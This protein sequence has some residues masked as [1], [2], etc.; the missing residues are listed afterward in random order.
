MSSSM[1]SADVSASTRLSTESLDALIVG[2]GPGG[3]Y[4]VHR[5]RDLGFDVRAVEAGSDVGGTWFWNRYPGARVDIESIEYSYSFS[6]QLEQEWVWTELMPAQP[7]IERYLNHVA[8]RFDLRR[9]IDF[10]TRITSLYYDDATQRWHAEADTGAR[11]DARFVIAATGCLSA[12]L[13]PDIEG[14]DTFAG[15]SLYTNNFPKSYDFTGKRVGVVGTGSSGVQ[16]IPVIAETAGE[17]SV[18]QRSAAYTK[19][20]NNRPLAHGELDEIKA[21]YPS[22]RARMSKTPTGTL[23]FG[24]VSVE[25]VP[26]PDRR[27]LDATDDEKREVLDGLGWNAPMAWGDV[28]FDLQAN[29]QATELYGELIA[30]VVTDPATAKALVPDYPMGCKRQIIDTDYFATY[31]KPNVSLVNLKQTPILRVTPEGI[32]TTDTTHDLDVIV[33]ATGFDA[34]TG[35]LERIHI[36]RRGGLTL[37]DKWKVGP[38]SYLGLQVAGFPNLFTITGPGSPSVTVNMMMAVEQHIDVVADLLV[39]MRERGLTSVEPTAQAEQDWVEHVASLVVGQVRGS[40]SCNS[41]YLGA[42]IPGK[43]RVYMPYTGG[44]PRYREQCAQIAAA[45]YTGFVLT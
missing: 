16:S 21:E 4:G 27:I 30:S 39:H 13:T 31:N 38:S 3:M 11:Y 5:L 28:A 12:P 7:E 26:P 34:M 36:H 9:N 35:A 40:D 41:W 37:K 6:T 45:N 2:A 20:A 44:M 29:Q 22:Y 33:Y 14:L 43:P 17:L 8:D 10:N 32:Q 1:S 24:A 42:N 18:F 25:N 19:P 15:D 23:R